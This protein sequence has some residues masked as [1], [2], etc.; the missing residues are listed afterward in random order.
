MNFR[1]TLAY[2]GT[3]F[4]GWQTQAGVQKDVRTV[5]DELA[6]VLVLLERRPVVVHGA[7]RTDAGVHAEAQT[8]S[9]R[10]ER[11]LPLDKLHKAINGNL[12]TDV[13][14]ARIKEMPDDFHARF[15][16]TGKTYRYRIFNASAVSPF[17]RRYALHEARPL[18]VER[19][20][21]AARLFAGTH[22]WT[23]F[24]CAQSDVASRVRTVTNVDVQATPDETFGGRII[25]ITAHGEGFLR[26]MVRGVAGALLAVGRGTI[27]EDRI[28]AALAGESRAGATAPPN[29]LTLVKVHYN[30]RVDGCEKSTAPIR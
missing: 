12:P 23:R 7:G 1:L 18:D 26:Y 13:R 6:R 19:M 15:S 20:R 21:D 10:L 29:G 17:L 27:G 24:S 2:D 4:H 3:D 28:R 9:V 14:V 16:A 22:D 11:D 30:P 5:Q 8:A 25:D